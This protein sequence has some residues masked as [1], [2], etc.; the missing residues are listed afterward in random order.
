MSIHRN[1]INGAILV[2][3]LLVTFTA[4][5]KD[6]ASPASA[7]D[8]NAI[9]TIS[10][11]Q[12]VQPLLNSSCATGGCHDE[13]TRA[14]GLSL[15]SWGELIKGSRFGEVII[16]SEPDRSLLTML[17]DGRTLRRNHPSLG[18]N[19]LAEAEL[20][21]LK[22]W[23][24]EGAR[25]DAGMAPYAHLQHKIYCPNQADDNVAILDSDNRLVT[26][27]VDVG[28]SPAN[29]APHFVVVG[30]HHWYVS[31]IGAGEVWQFDIHADTLVRKAPVP[32]APALLSLTPD[33]SKLYVSQFMTSSTN[34]VMVINTAT[35]TVA[36]SITVWTMPHGMR[37]NRTGTRLYVANMM[38]DNISVIDPATDSVIATVPVAHDALP[39]GPTKY[40]PM[41][42]ALSPDDGSYMVTC[43]SWDEVRMFDASTNALVD[44]FRVGSQ[45]WHLQYTPDGEFCYVTNRLGNSVSVIH[46]PMRHVMS[47]ITA[48]TALAY[49][50]GVDIS[51]DGRYVFVSNENVSHQYVP[52]YNP[53]FVGN[54]A[55]IDHVSGQMVKV[56]EVGR[57]PTGLAVAR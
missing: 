3:A 1:S 53:E 52:R 14:A 30:P 55:V 36:K 27:Y 50:H 6:E 39:F 9:S 4:C 15:T 10:Y 24:R 13:G 48:S 43:S 2:F 28:T 56:V 20:S 57:M 41:E 19:S 34:R 51:A 42:V 32:G 18:G 17:F 21:F 23:I 35:M 11:S 5:K 29:D 33:G 46:V 54:I 7:L 12:H 38:S 25:N 8:Y 31:L 22:R 49:P 40:M 45:P 37:M 16:A 44:S 26:R 47:T